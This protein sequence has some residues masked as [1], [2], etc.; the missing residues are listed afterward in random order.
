LLVKYFIK[1][2]R[3]ASSRNNINFYLKPSFGKEAPINVSLK[4]G[5]EFELRMNQNLVKYTN[6]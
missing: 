2:K 6:P 3:I 5:K 1:K 4:L